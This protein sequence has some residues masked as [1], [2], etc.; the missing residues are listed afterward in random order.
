MLVHPEEY[1][2]R[3]VDVVA[4]ISGIR[5]NRRQ[6]MLF[7]NE[8]LP[9]IRIVLDTDVPDFP[10]DTEGKNIRV[11]GLF[12][13]IK[14]TDTT[15]NMAGNSSTLLKFPENNKTV[16]SPKYLIVCRFYEPAENKKVNLQ[17]E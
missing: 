12:K 16:I 13:V 6:A 5:D 11:K 15:E 3:V 10:A 8:N 14:D 1:Q 9:T 4:R 2:G 17:P 7:W